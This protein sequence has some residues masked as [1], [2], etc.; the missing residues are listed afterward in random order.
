[1]PPSY[2]AYSVRVN[3]RKE[4]LHS[5]S[6]AQ[7]VCTGVIFSESNNRSR[8]TDNIKD[9]AHDLIALNGFPV[10]IVVN[11]WKGGVSCVTS[12]SKILHEM[13]QGYHQTCLEISGTYISDIIAFDDILFGGEY[14]AG[15]LIIYEVFGKKIGFI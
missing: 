11:I 3:W 13:V 1:M 2:Q 4:Q 7:V 9:S 12:L 6:L 8:V 15:K 5:S 14:Q 10:F